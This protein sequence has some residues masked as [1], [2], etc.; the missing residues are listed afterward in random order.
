MAAN[1]ETSTLVLWTYRA[2]HLLRRCLRDTD[3]DPEEYLTHLGR[4]LSATWPKHYIVVQDVMTGYR[5]RS[6]WFILLVE[7][8]TGEGAP[9][10]A[11]V[12]KLVGPPPYTEEKEKDQPPAK[13]KKELQNWQKCAPEGLQHDVV[14]L[15]LERGYPRDEK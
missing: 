8:M 13:L 3:A 7:V 9:C 11:N 1:G 10:G 12:V 15:P 6:S 2:R 4:L 5:P 14:F